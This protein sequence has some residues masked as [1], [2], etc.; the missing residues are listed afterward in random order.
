M[1]RTACNWVLTSCWSKLL[2]HGNLIGREVVRRRAIR[3]PDHKSSVK[4]LL[5]AA[6]D[7]LTFEAF[8]VPSRFKAITLD[9]NLPDQS[10][11]R[12]GLEADNTS[13]FLFRSNRLAWDMCHIHRVTP[14][15]DCYFNNALRRFASRAPARAACLRAVSRAA[16]S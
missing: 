6:A 4:S 7:S 12:F 9:L 14:K 8:N 5:W 2:I 13:S 10:D 16:V 1:M 11:D 15:D 3:C